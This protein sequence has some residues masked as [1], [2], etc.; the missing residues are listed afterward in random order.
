MKG[1]WAVRRRKKKEG[2]KRRMKKEERTI[3]ERDTFRCRTVR[4]G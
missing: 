4:R 2:G 1:R 3:R